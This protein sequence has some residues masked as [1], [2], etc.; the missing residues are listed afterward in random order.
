MQGDRWLMPWK[1]QATSHP[2]A[3]LKARWWWWGEGSCRVCDQLVHSSLRVRES[4][5]VTGSIFISL[6]LQEAWCWVLMV[7]KWLNLPLGRGFSHLQNNSGNVPWILL[8]QSFR[9]E[10]KQK[11]W[12][13]SCPCHLALREPHGVLLLFKRKM[14]L[15]LCLCSCLTIL[16]SY[17]LSCVSLC[18]Y[19]EF[20]A[21]QLTNCLSL[22]SWSVS[23][24][25]WKRDFLHP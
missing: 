17:T 22:Y 18:E 7:I 23:F 25:D 6:S 10:L 9:E 13:K 1:P 12:G 8:S 19:E 11:M 4:G 21:F 2:Q 3:L 5:G 20:L 14:C 16:H 15:W 24:A